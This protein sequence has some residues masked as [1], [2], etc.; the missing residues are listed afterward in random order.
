M[1]S[2]SNSDQEQDQGSEHE[3]EQEQEQ[4]EDEEEEEVIEQKVDPSALQ[5]PEETVK[6][7]I[8]QHMRI[9]V[10]NKD[11]NCICENDL[12]N[13]YYCIP[14][15]SSC[16]TKCSLP[17]HSTHLL[18][19]KEK[20]F[21]KPSQIDASFGLVEYMLEKDDL[22][23]NMEE[24]RKEL[25]NEI[26]TTCK[27]IELLVKEF[28]EKRYKQINDLFDDLLAN[29]KDV[30]AK[31]K[32]AKKLLNN[33]AEKHKNFFGLLDQNKDPH[34]TIFLI[35]YDLISI[36]H[37]WSE[38]MTE[39]G[40]E[41]EENMLDYKTREE[42]KNRERIRK[43]KEILFLNDDEDPITHE[44]IDEKLLPLVKLR[45]GINDF[46]GDQ[47]KDIDR[48]INK[49]NK[50]IDNFKSSVINSIRKHGNYKEL[51]KENNI[52]EH[53]KVKGADNLF[54][55]RKMDA[56]SKGDENYLLPSHHIKN[57]NDI[58]LDNQILNRNY[59]HVMTDLYDQYF[60][61]PTIELQSSHA[62]LKFKES[63]NNNGGDD[64]S[65]V[66]KV[67]EN[68]NQ[69]KIYDKKLKKI[70]VK[71]LKLVKNP[72]GYTKFPLGCRSVLVGDKLYI[73][74]GKDEFM[75]YAVCLIYDRKTEKI[76]RIM[77]MRNPR[78]YHTM[79]FN[80]VFETMMVIGGEYNFTVEIFDP[81]SNRWQELPELNIPRAIPLFYF[82]EGRGNMYVLFGVE[83]DYHKPKQIHT[84]SIEI[85]DLTELNQGW[86]KINYNNKASMDLK[87]FLNIYPLNDF[88][89]LIYGGLE[90]RQSKRN[91]CIYNLV[92]AEMTKI[93]KN[94]MDELRN[95]SKN[96][97]LLNN[98][99]MSVSKNSIA[100][101]SE[102][103]RVL[104]K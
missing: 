72:H 18:I 44:R 51:A 24:K 16:C 98:I 29:I 7:D 71:K 48:R 99:I 43:I 35:N 9:G 83:G 104:K 33:F 25:L 79:I 84:D 82:D 80:D 34:N 103:S 5:V 96:N 77:D 42:N 38:K 19:P 88:L 46:N 28:K 92:K 67:I 22:F 40:K 53:R 87:C 76:K 13:L 78:S 36:P 39:V 69:I 6:I 75:E 55:Q 95:E 21:L 47:L 85:L 86:M 66:C 101:L 14:C 89:L 27:N 73:T 37:L 59:T 10:K 8:F 74:G 4:N 49:L 57:K 54:S 91:A 3:Q 1:D 2:N 17:E 26:D 15:K 62:D 58:V 81:L 94:L 30:N 56:L 52:Y 60:R 70:I 23:K 90:S 12:E 61:I 32:E 64:I 41:I 20:Y 65:N 100:D 31:K 102:S 50:G 63:E 45:V 11:L 97:K 93:D 68:T